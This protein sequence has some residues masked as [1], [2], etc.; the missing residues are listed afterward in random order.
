[1]ERIETDN[2]KFETLAWGL[3]L[4][5][6]GA[7]WGFLEDGFLPAGTGALGLGLILVGLNVARWFKGIPISTLSSSLGALFLI[8]GA[9]KLA[10]RTL[11]CPCLQMPAFALF[12]IILG[13]IVLARELLPAK[14]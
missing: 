11:D 14:G 13:G 1:M 3:L 2:R 6:L 10:G 8:L 5:W 7:W 4:V 9:M 12:L